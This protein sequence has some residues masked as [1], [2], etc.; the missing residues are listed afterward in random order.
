MTLQNTERLVIHNKMD[1][2]IRLRFSCSELNLW[3]SWLE[4]GGSLALPTPLFASVQCQSSY[5]SST[6]GV[7][8]LQSFPLQDQQA[9]GAINCQLVAKMTVS[10]GCNCFCVDQEEHGK[11]GSI[12]MLNLTDNHVLF[13]FS[14]N[15]TPFQFSCHLAAQ[16]SKDLQLDRFSLTATSNGLTCGPVL[17]KQW[18]GE[19]LLIS[20]SEKPACPV[21]QLFPPR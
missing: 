3:D 4:R 15:Q 21:I 2:R 9:A 11:P 16:A 20:E 17:I 7:Q 12:G 13:S 14:F 5:E 8:Y 6:T 18:A 1:S 19:I 10:Q